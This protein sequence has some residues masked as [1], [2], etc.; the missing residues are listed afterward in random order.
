MKPKPSAASESSATPSLFESRCQA[1]RIG[2]TFQTKAPQL[3]ERA[4]L[5]N[6]DR[7]GSLLV[8]A[9]KLRDLSA[10]IVGSVSGGKAKE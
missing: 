9:R 7:V 6:V 4:T 5:K 2:K 1:D 10:S 8:P 3:A